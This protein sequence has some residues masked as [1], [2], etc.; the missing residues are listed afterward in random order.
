M[1]RNCCAR[2]CMPR[3]TMDPL[4]AA[5]CDIANVPRTSEVLHL[6]NRWQDGQRN[7]CELALVLLNLG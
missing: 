6:I 4:H 7:V 5:H 3:G 1:E 2:L